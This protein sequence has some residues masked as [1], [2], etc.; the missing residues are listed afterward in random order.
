MATLEAQRALAANLDA[1]MLALA[2]E[3]VVDPRRSSLST[4]QVQRALVQEQLNAYKYPV[5]TLPTEIICEIFIHFLP[6]Y[7]ECPPP[8]GILSPTNLTQICRQWRDIA[9]ATPMLWRAV[10]MCPEDAGV[11]QQMHELNISIWLGRSLGC[12]FSI[13][14]LTPY[15]SRRGFMF[16]SAQSTRLEYLKVLLRAS[17]SLVI[18]E[19]PMPLLRHLDLA[20]QYPEMSEPVVFPDAPLLRSAVLNDNAI[21]AVV[22]PWAQLTELTLHRVFPEECTPVLQL[23]SNLVYCKLTIAE[24]S[25]VHRARPDVTLLCLES[26]TLEPHRLNTKTSGY[27]ETFIV[28]TLCHLQVKEQLL[29]SEPVDSLTTFVSKSEC[30]LEAIYISGKRRLSEDVYRHAF[31]SIELSFDEA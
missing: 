8:A 18:E 23:T 15:G 10:Y 28:P 25:G 9:L 16:S 3:I 12:P 20:F 26:L 1:Q 4:L 24:S 21:Q 17:S 5:L 14:I 13:E 31:P 19:G 30:T 29:G 2:D 7:P 22:L 11:V 6:V 27:L